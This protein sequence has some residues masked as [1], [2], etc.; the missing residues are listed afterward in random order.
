[1]I[2][3]Y[4][5]HLPSRFSPVRAKQLCDDSGVMLVGNAAC[6][7]DEGTLTKSVKRAHDR[8]GPDDD[9]YRDA[10][11]LDRQ[12]E[13]D[14]LSAS[15]STS[16][17]NSKRR[18][19]SLLPDDKYAYTISWN[20]LSFSSDEPNTIEAHNPKFRGGVAHAIEQCAYDW[21]GLKELSA[22][23]TEK[24]DSYLVAGDSAGA[25]CKLQDVVR[26][27][28]QFLSCHRDLPLA[29]LYDIP[30][31]TPAST[32]NSTSPATSPD[33]LE[34]SD[35]ER[36]EQKPPDQDWIRYREH[37]SAVHAILGTALFLLGK[38]IAQ[39]PSLART[40]EPTNPSPYWLIALDVFE[41]GDN[42]PSPAWGQRY[43]N[44]VDDNWQMYVV[45]GR[46]LV[47]LADLATKKASEDATNG[48]SS[49]A[50]MYRYRKEW[51]TSSPFAA[52]IAHCSPLA[53]TM[54]LSDPSAHEFL[55]LAM[56]QFS[57]GIFHMPRPPLPSDDSLC[58]YNAFLP[59]KF[60]HEKELFT[61]A[62]DVLDVA[63]HLE[64]PSERR[65]WASWVD[66]VF[67]QIE[68]GSAG[69]Y[70]DQAIHS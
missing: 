61:I 50:S 59:T 69:I 33:N 57:R 55:M 37:P 70:N 35:W 53:N 25:L 54:S 60:C 8:L 21:E 6:R 13:Y 62:S 3:G 56:D 5:L 30:A 39:D 24:Y 2:L 1:M 17:S 63:E 51:P 34:S 26:G 10:L 67:K 43:V 46:V 4:T 48:S 58:E 44:I 23:A 14:S 65:Y 7:S 11:V 64:V 41:A 9:G 22:E 47:A 49:Q 19:I 68:V 12:L 27:C 32:Q 28:N 66:S 52:I 38:L 15:S 18:R 29:R 36:E 20:K 42:L 31:A 45:W 16:S 40:G